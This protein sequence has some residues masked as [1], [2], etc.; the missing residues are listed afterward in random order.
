MGNS[1]ESQQ[2]QRDVEPLPELLRGALRP[3]EEMTRERW[4]RSID[5]SWEL[6]D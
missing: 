2:P 1:D 3:A 6:D 5:A 4:E